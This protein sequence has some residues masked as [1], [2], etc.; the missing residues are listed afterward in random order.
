[1]N[2]L[3][4]T[5]SAH[6]DAS[7]SNQLAAHFAEQAQSAHPGSRIVVRDLG[8]DP[9]PHLVEET[10]AG[11]RA[12]ATTAAEI[13]VRDL[14]DELIGELR[15]AD[16]IVIGSPMYNFGISSPLKAWFDHVLRPRVTFRY[17]DNG[18]EGLLGGRKAIVI[19]SRAGYYPAGDPTDNQEPHL[20]QML[21]FVGIEDVTFVRAEKLAFGPDAAAGSVAEAKERLSDLA[22]QSLSL[23]A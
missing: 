14:S 17:G 19:E 1:M 5:S 21:K 9:I 11:I 15:D 3:I 22:R 20:K 6:G 12:E 13:A 23:A 10:V 2:I 7:V 18:A 8:R 4:V 16:L